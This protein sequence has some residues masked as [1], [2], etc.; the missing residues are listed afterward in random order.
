MPSATTSPASRIA[1]VGGGNMARSLVGGLVAQGADPASIRVAE[2]VDALRDALARDFGV[3]T[4]ARGEDA[5]PGADTWVMAVATCSCATVR[6]FASQRAPTSYN[7]R[8][9]TS[10]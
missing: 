1:F 5:V 9:K 4:F 3:A 8:W 7:A 10:T 6:S 2:P